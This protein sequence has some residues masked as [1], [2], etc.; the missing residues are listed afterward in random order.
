MN[1]GRDGGTWAARLPFYYGWVVVAGMALV[2]M[3]ITLMLGANVGVFIRPMGDDLGI[4]STPFGLAQTARLL[5]FAASG[6]VVGRLL[7]RFGARLPMTAAGAALGAG[8]AALGLV[9][10]GWQLVA[11]FA[12]VGLIGFQ[13]GQA[14]Y[15]TVPIASWFERK[16]GKAMAFAFSGVPVGIGVSGPLTQALIDWVGW[17]SAWVVLGVGG[18]AVI[19]LAALLLVRRRPEDMGLEIDGD[20]AGGEAEAGGARPSGAGEYPWTRQ[21]AMRTPA[22][23]MLAVAFGLFM[24]G[25]TSL[26]VF[27][28]DFFVE[29]GLSPSVAAWSL[30]ADAA[31]STAVSVSAGLLPRPFQPAGHRGVGVRRAGG[32]L[33]GDDDDGERGADDGGDAAVRPGHRDG[34]GGAER[35]LACLLRT[36][37]SG[38]DTRQRAAGYAGVQRPGRAGRRADAGLRGRLLRGVVDG[39]RAVPRGGGAHPRHAQAPPAG[40][41]RGED[42]GLTRRS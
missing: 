27:R 4:G 32:V 13:S 42:R 12:V 33:R 16:R 20:P 18:G 21:E 37:P 25:T 17:R 22:F 35:H 10:E 7:D 8:V 30:M 34:D 29:R 19:V 2:G 39:H 9:R 38:S 1:T 28:I 26:S 3:T 41:G 24:F 11:L 23:W 6:L 31:A 36:R 5:A 40:G 14:L 15:T